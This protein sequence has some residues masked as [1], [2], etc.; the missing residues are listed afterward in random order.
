MSFKLTVIFT[1][2][3]VVSCARLDNEQLNRQIQQQQELVQQ[4]N[5]RIRDQQQLENQQQ[6]DQVRDLDEQSRRQE[7]MIRD[8]Q[9]QRLERIRSNGN[10]FITSLPQFLSTGAVHF[11]A[12]PSS[13][14]AFNY[15]DDS[16]YN[17]EYAVNDAST[18]D[19]KSQNEVRRGDQVQ[20]QYTMVDADGYQRIVDYHADD[21]NGFDAEVRREP[22]LST[23]QVYAAQYRHQQPIVQVFS[24]Q[25]SIFSTTS[26][27]RRDEGQ[28]SQYSTSTASNF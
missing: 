13:Q 6:R 11:V 25:P 14:R 15:F 8:Q 9:Q 27:S 22:A 3:A 16:N 26:V 7:Q 17:F 19:V 10:V 1:T 24:A 2:L 23:Q 4:Q 20:G 12:V 21:V 18:G 5:D 28:Q